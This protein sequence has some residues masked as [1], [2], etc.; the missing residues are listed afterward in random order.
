MNPGSPTFSPSVV[1]SAVLT[2]KTRSV[3]TQCCRVGSGAT[4][5]RN[6]R[7]WLRRDA[8]ARA[9][10]GERAGARNPVRRDAFCE[11]VVSQAASPHANR[12]RGGWLVVAEALLRSQFAQLRR[13]CG[14]AALHSPWVAHN[15][16]LLAIVGSHPSS[17][18]ARRNAGSIAAVAS[19]FPCRSRK[20][21]GSTL[22][23]MPLSA[24]TPAMVAS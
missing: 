5:L 23:R 12:T 4:A 17:R 6:A 22:T 9:L 21:S 20:N 7:V 15:C 13:L 8:R 10:A 14:E 16:P 18:K 3:A 11:V 19:A 1:T 2:Y 24:P